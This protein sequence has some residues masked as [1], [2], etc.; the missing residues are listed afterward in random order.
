MYCKEL[1]IH[2]ASHSTGLHNCQI[3]CT[4][5]GEA[6]TI[7]PRFA[8]LAF[9]LRFACFAADIFLCPSA[10]GKVISRLSYPIGLYSS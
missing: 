4:R 9:R 2:D 8:T 3:E 6:G 10:S 5:N 1:G 7:V